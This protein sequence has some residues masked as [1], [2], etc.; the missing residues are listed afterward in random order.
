MFY[1]LIEKVDVMNES[2]I[3]KLDKFATK[4]LSR[5]LFL[6]VKRIF[7]LFCAI[8]GCI[9]LIPIIVIIKICYILTGDFHSIFYSHERIGQYG[10][11]FKLYKFRSMV[12]NADVELQ[13]ILKNDKQLA[14]EYSENKKLVNDPRIT[15]I[16]KF[17]RK[18]SIDET[19]QF[20][21]VLLGNMSIIGNRPYLPREKKDMGNYYHDIVM[22]KPGITGYWQVSGRNDVSFKQRLKLEKYYSNNQ[23]LKMDIIIFFKTF[24]VVICGRGAK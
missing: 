14:K 18:L 23:S 21:N 2:E 4:S 16:G 17:I 20:I 7:D 1:K 19:P 15:T 22:T 24:Y 8:I 5:Y 6:I 12:P 3:L 13:K 10:A 11:T 9:L